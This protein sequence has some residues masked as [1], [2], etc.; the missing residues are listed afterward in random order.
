[1]R[2]AAGM[3]ILAAA[4]LLLCECSRESRVIEAGQP[5]TAQLPELDPALDAQDIAAYLVTLR[6]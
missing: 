6:R 3:P 2:A 1:M 4:M 5:V